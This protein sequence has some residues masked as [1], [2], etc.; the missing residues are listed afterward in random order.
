MAGPSLPPA[1]QAAKGTPPLVLLAGRVL[2]PDGTLRED[3]AVLIQDGKIRSVQP[4]TAGSLSPAPGEQIRRFG[5]QSMIC[6]GLIDLFSS[7][8]AVGQAE[9]TALFVDPE[10]RAADAVDPRHPDFGLALRS[11]VTTAMVAPAPNNL[12]NGVCVS[13]RTFVDH[14]KLDVLRDDGPLVFALGEG[15]WREDRAPTSR[16]GA[17]HELRALLRDA[18]NATAHPRLSALVAGRLDGLIVCQTAHDVAA[19]QS[20][21]GELSGRFA[22]VHTEDAVELAADL[23]GDGTHLSAAADPRSTQ[24]SLAAFSRQPMV[25]GPY[26]FTCCAAG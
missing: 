7:I 16:A 18:R 19:A 5:P 22:L 23:K 12:V 15:V 6:P 17:L 21:L 8:G 10:A 14:G 13:F 3:M 9:E 4:G 25:V 1:T 26:A 24:A 20:G 11:G 2:R